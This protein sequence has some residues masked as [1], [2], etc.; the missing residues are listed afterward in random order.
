MKLGVRVHDLGRDEASALA[1]KAKQ[2]GFDGVQL[3]VTKALNG[4]GK[5]PTELN[6][7]K[8]IRIR[9]AFL[10]EG[11]DIY[12]LGAYFNPVHSNK[13]KL[14]N[15]INNFK[16]YLKYESLFKASYVGSETGSFNDE[17]W[18]YHPQNRT[19]EGYNQMRDVFKEL[20]CYA[21]EYN[22]KM[23]LEGAYGHV[24][25][26]PKVLRQLYEDINYDGL[27]FTLDLYN[28]LDISNYKNY[29]EIL[30]EAIETLKDRVRII[31]LKDFIVVDNK[32]VKVDLGEGIID[33]KTV[34]KKLLTNFKDAYFIFEG[35]SKEGMESSYKFIKKVESEI[36]NEI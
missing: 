33:Y 31:H 27:Y 34:L 36:N 7:E 8:V 10:N 13:E 28:Y 9:D 21:K 23:A 5:I 20:A 1:K 26:S 3:V 15:G 30:D 24:C 22:A 32:L 18:I 19:V 17:P 4:E 16:N 6:E 2:I 14:T 12:M 35:I 29:M 11:L 25:Y